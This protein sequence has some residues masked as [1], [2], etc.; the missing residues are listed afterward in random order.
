MESSKQGTGFDQPTTAQSKL[1]RPTKEEIQALKK[2]HWEEFMKSKQKG[3][4]E[5]DL[6]DCPYDSEDTALPS[7]DRLN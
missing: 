1:K 7:S 3:V 2:A 6:T 4:A 5:A